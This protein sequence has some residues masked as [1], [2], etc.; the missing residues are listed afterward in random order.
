[1][2]PTTPVLSNDIDWF[3]AYAVVH[4][5]SETSWRYAYLF[6]LIV[7]FVSLVYS[8]CH[9]AGLRSGVVG[10]YWSKWS[11]RRRTWRKSHSLALARK[12]GE[13]R[14]QSVPL[15]SN[16]QLLCF[17]SLVAVSFALMFVGPDYLAPQDKLWQ[18][19][20]RDTVDPDSFL[21]YRPQY[22]IQK[23]WWTSGGRTGLFAFALFPLC[24]LFVLKAP[25][26][27]LFAIS[28]LT[29]FHFDKLIW[30]HRWTGRL[31]WL[32]AAIHT[33]LWSVQLFNDKRVDTNKM[34]YV[35]AWQYPNFI[36]A[37]TA[38]GLLTMI[39]LLSLR[40]IRD[41]FYESF[42]FLHLL[43]VPLM[44]IMSALHHPPLWW[45]CWA[46]LGLWAGERIW[47]ATRWMYINGVVG[48][49]ATPSKSIHG[50]SKRAWEMVS[51]KSPD[52][53]SALPNARQVRFATSSMPEDRHAP[54]YSVNTPHTP[55]SPYHASVPSASSDHF[56]LP[57]PSANPYVPPTGYAHAELLAGRTV[58]LRF[59]PPGFI[60]WAPGQHFL[61]C[62]P[63]VSKILS[64]PF[65]CASICDEQTM[66]DEGRTIVLLIRAKNGWTKDLWDAIV[67]LI[68]SGHKHPRNEVPAGTTLPPT[69]VLL[70][71]WVDGPFGS[72][73]RVSWGSYSSVLIVS[74]GS[75]VTFGL[76]VLEYLC[77]CMAGRNGKFLG[78]KTGWGKPAFRTQRIRFVWVLR[79]FSHIQWC[80]TVL[81][82]C[83]TLIPRELLQ[84]ELFVTNFQTAPHPAITPYAETPVTA[85][86][87]SLFPPAPRFAKN[88]RRGGQGESGS[89]SEDSHDDVD[90]YVDLSYY[91]GNYEGLDGDLGDGDNILDLTNFD[92]DNDE[93]LP[94]EASVNRTV[95]KEGKLRRAFTRKVKHDGVRSSLSPT[96]FGPSSVPLLSSAPKG[97]RHGQSSVSEAD[98]TS[99]ALAGPSSPRHSRLSQSL[100]LDDSR[101]ELSVQSLSMTVDGP[102][103]SRSLLGGD[104]D[105]RSIIS[106]ASSMHALMPKVGRG[107]HGVEVKLELDERELHDM[108]VMAEFARPGRPK[109]DFVLHDEVARAKGS[110]VVACCGPAALNAVVRK[111]IAAQ[112]DPARIRRGDM[113]GSISLVAEE[114]SY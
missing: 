44:I 66:G 32:V 64:H 26:F 91:T 108:H 36:Y 47:R 20:R 93:R 87:D 83:T 27:A 14:K 24:I 52:T 3:T 71:C 8:A 105:T 70:R 49:S 37:W 101:P 12:P 74:G 9:W 84:I 65:T 72:S 96:R 112:I 7:A 106:Q 80:A 63:S 42:Y 102:F 6:W 88:A 68:A 103:S 29:D 43:L 21:P 22:T 2:N 62:V 28:F 90:N 25:P 86:S 48:S 113:S 35:Y 23:A 107:R 31:I 85:D 34:A 33:A 95:R 13:P 110:V 5:L 75:G 111:A 11:I 98:V 1:P 114:F 100:Q 73:A 79:E 46:A 94:G 53:E 109:L 99:M 58:R 92:G 4:R 40:P 78:G 16:A 57:V 76:S 104:S 56:L 45:W 67:T 50:D 59:A 89:D 10:A 61:L 39:I 54:S 55:S 18:F 81:R 41:R 60:S 51:L 82:R 77:L 38:F 19:G 15:P 69:G 17:F 30:L 97:H